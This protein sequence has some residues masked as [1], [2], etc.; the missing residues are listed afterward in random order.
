[1]QHLLQ[2][3]FFGVTNVRIFSHL[4]NEDKQKSIVLNM[5]TVVMVQKNSCEIYPLITSIKPFFR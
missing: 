1:M 5:K 3:L 2:R 4:E